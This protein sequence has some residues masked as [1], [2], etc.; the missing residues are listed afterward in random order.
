MSVP[1][2]C[3][4]LDTEREAFK[5][6]KETHLKPILASSCVDQLYGESIT[7]D[8]EDVYNVQEKNYLTFLNRVATDLK[9]D[10]S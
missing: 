6:N 2:L 9:L 10:I 3:I 5:L 7:S 4:H 8:K 1:S